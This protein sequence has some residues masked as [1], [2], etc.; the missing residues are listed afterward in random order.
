MFV[1]R[2]VAAEAGDETFGER[3]MSPEHSLMAQTFGERQ[4]RS[5]YSA[6]PVRER[7]LD[8]PRLVAGLDGAGHRVVPCDRMLQPLV[9][10][11]VPAPGE[12]MRDARAV[13]EQSTEGGRSGI[14]RDVPRRRCRPVLAIPGCSD[15]RRPDDA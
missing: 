10:L 15:H 5:R 6:D 8:D 1:Q 4:T 14:L 3:T 11:G 13:D 12:G 2:H 9:L 7:H